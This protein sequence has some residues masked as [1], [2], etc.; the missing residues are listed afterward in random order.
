MEAAPY[1]PVR[2]KRGAAEYSEAPE[3]LEAQAFIS[4]RLQSN[5]ADPVFLHAKGRAEL[6]GWHFDEAIQ[7]L[8]R[9]AD[10]G[11]D[12]AGFWVDF[13]TAFFERG[14]ANHTTED[15]SQAAKKLAT[16]LTK[17]PGWSVALFNLGIVHGRLGRPDLAKADFQ[18]VLKTETDEGWRQE[19]AR[20]LG[21]LP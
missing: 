16:A 9:A 2:I 8:Q 19:T 18:A 14:E 21:E 4:R 1:G 15:H 5:P 11:R 12:D 20:R 13:G 17:R 3:V 10:L 6:L 7:T